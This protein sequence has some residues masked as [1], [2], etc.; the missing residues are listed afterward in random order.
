ML[1]LRY[2]YLKNVFWHIQIKIRLKNQ[3][4]IGL[5][6][7][8]AG[9]RLNTRRWFLLDY[10]L[11][12]YQIGSWAIVFPSSFMIN[13]GIFDLYIKVWISE[14]DL[15]LLLLFFSSQSELH[16]VPDID[17]FCYT[18]TYFIPIGVIEERTTRMYPKYFNGKLWPYHLSCFI[19]S[20]LWHSV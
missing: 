15:H 6:N 10:S 3:I 20:F 12:H 9:Q 11:P 4:K 19:N 16:S 13:L 2:P 18:T 7:H 1:I 14:F 17:F 5:K 8:E